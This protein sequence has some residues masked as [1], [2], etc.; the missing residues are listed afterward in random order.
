MSAENQTIDLSKVNAAEL[1]RELNTR[2]GYKILRQSVRRREF[3]KLADEPVLKA[4]ILD[5]ETTGLDCK[6]H[7]VIEVGAIL[8]EV[9]TRTGNVGRVLGILEELEQ[10]KLAIPPEIEEI[11]G[12]TNVMVE[13]K[14]F[15]EQRIRAAFDACDF[16]IAHNAQFDRGFID[17]R[18]PEIDKPW[19]CSIEDLSWKGAGYASNTLEVIS[20]QNGFFYDPHRAVNDCFALAHSLASPMKKTGLMPMLALIESLKKLQFHVIATA[21]PFEKKGLLK[22]RGYKFDD[23][24]RLWS[25]AFSGTDEDF[26]REHDFLAEEIYE[27][28]N[29]VFHYQ[30]KSHNERYGSFCHDPVAQHVFDPAHP[31]ETASSAPAA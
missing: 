12:I 28:A 17:E 8:V 31:F 30:V 23:S 24:T 9:G 15:N 13:G 19:V 6:R 27:R 18:F 16:V 3:R 29:A 10:P 7:E 20:M 26:D 21:S 4:L 22:A 5:T 1:F 11:T 14:A 2:E 25:R